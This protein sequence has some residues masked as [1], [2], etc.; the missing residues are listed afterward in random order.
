MPLQWLFLLITITITGLAINC[1]WDLSVFVSTYWHIG[2]GN[3]FYPRRCLHGSLPLSPLSGWTTQWPSDLQCWDARV[4]LHRFAVWSTPTESLIPSPSPAKW[5]ST[6]WTVPLALRIPVEFQRILAKSYLDIGWH[7]TY[8]LVI[9]GHKWNLEEFAT[10]DAIG[11]R[12]FKVTGLL[13]RTEASSTAAAP[14]LARPRGHG[15]RQPGA[16]VHRWPTRLDVWG[17]WSKCQRHLK[18]HKDE[19][20]I[21]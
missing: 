16:S 20:K 19:I 3:I 2:V 10:L 21:I 13:L 5:S 8:F 1:S 7:W 15:G 17:R 4:Q 6:G 11:C 14:V 18:I 12:S 9:F